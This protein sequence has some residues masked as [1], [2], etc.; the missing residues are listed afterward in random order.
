[1]LG[2]P[3]PPTPDLSVTPLARQVTQGQV[4][5]DLV[6][7]R[8]LQCNGRVRQRDIPMC[9][10]TRMHACM[11]ALGFLLDRC[12]FNR[13]VAG[14][15]SHSKN[16]ERAKERIFTL[17]LLGGGWSNCLRKSELSWEP[18]ADTQCAALS[19]PG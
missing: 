19:S 13:L 15:P 2:I 16:A 17:S 12:S 1:M 6:A 3:A 9:S 10:R 11:E 7:L 8:R 4:S 5:T 18:E 14:H